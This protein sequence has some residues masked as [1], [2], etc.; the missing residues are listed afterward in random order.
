MKIK[1]YIIL[2]I[3]S[4]LI[5]TLYFYLKNNFG[6]SSKI[7][8]YEDTI[9]SLEKQIIVINTKIEKLDSIRVNLDSQVIENKKQLSKIADKAAYYQRRYN[10][11]QDRLRHMSND[12]II[13]EFSDVFDYD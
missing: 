12:D 5:G 4:I 2:L 10:E 9:D 13:A 1:Y 11:E 7:Q 3:G 6:E 8:Q